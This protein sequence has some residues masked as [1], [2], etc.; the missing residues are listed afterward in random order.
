[1]RVEAKT[2]EDAYYEAAKK[3]NCSVTDLEV[4]IIQYP[5]RGLFGLFSKT[6]II[7][8][9]DNIQRDI[10]DVI[11]EIKEQLK[12]LFEKSCFNLDTF[13]VYKYDEETVFIKIDGEDAA[14]L[15]GKE[16]YRYNALNFMLYSWINQKYGFKVRLEIAEFLKTQ[17]EML[18]SF[19]APFIEKVRERGY[20]KT[21]PFDGILAFI[22]LEILRE[23]FPDRYVA[24]KDRNGEKFVVIGEK[25]GN[26][27]GNSDA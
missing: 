10:E 20:G 3:L 15:I 9:D 25:H 11:P 2:L 16:G 14:L 5:S 13:E 27:S 21:K 19:L 24:I 12:K 26:N 4:T 18:R 17:E 23:E 1:M 8:V 22:A 7:E 6:A